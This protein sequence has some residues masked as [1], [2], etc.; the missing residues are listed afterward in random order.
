MIILHMLSKM[1]LLNKLDQNS[2]ICT[3]NLKL[4][5]GFLHVFGF[6]KSFINITVQTKTRSTKTN[7][8]T[9]QQLDF[10][11]CSSRRLDSTLSWVQLES[12]SLVVSCNF[13]NKLEKLCSLNYHRTYSEF[14]F[15]SDLVGN[16]FF[17]IYLNLKSLITMRMAELC[18][19]N[20]HYSTHL[21]QV[22]LSIKINL[23]VNCMSHQNE[24][25]GI[26]TLQVI[27]H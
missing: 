6:G 25:E 14:Q 24:C 8:S 23:L 9:I 16:F 10:F 7:S 21:K 3:R 27:C 4:H 17:I 2:Q 13:W 11:V 26:I 1:Y 20:Q 19:L 15:L 22:K 12:A 5:S 18:P